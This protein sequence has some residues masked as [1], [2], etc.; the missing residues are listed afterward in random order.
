MKS[1]FYGIEFDSYV[2]MINQNFVFK[3]Q[4]DILKIILRNTMCAIYFQIDVFRNRFIN[5]RTFSCIP[6]F[7]T[8]F[9]TQCLSS[10][11]KYSSPHG[12]K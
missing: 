5:S 4:L 9:N 10:P 8:S 1:H 3:Y 11:N 7:Y 12:N 6:Q 2:C